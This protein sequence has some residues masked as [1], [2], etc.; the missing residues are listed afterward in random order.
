MRKYT[1]VMLIISMFFA[2]SSVVYA[3]TPR[4]ENNIYWEKTSLTCYIDSNIMYDYGTNISS[5]IGDGILSWNSTDA[6]TISLS[7]DYINWDVIVEMYDL[8]YTG[9]DADCTT[10]P[11]DNNHVQ[12]TDYAIIVINSGALSSYLNNA[13]L[14]KALACH[15]MG[16]AHGL[17]HNTND[18]DSIMK[19]YT[20]DYYNYSGT[21]P[22]WTTPRAADKA[23]VNIIY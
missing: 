7:D 16:H 2:L 15:E 23:G 3:V 22:R 20:I 10:Y 1:S 21:S 12:I 11:V 14:W 13:N 9:W 8:G 6:P 18:E 5:A 19:P 17:D 4:F